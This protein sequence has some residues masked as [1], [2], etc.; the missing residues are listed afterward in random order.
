MYSSSNNSVE[1]INDED[2]E[3]GLEDDAIR[4][5]TTC[6]MGSI[7]S[8][9]NTFAAICQEK[10]DLVQWCRSLSVCCRVENQFNVSC[11]QL[12]IVMVCLRIMEVY[13]QCMKI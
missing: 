6:T 1:E 3:E 12:E 2:K 4:E 8:V 7:T 11:V 5:S 10:S 13:H 9:A